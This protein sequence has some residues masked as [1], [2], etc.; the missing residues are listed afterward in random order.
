M[1]GRGTGN[2]LHSRHSEPQWEPGGGRRSRAVGRGTPP[3][4]LSLPRL[5]GLALWLLQTRTTRTDPSVTL[6]R[7]SERMRR[8]VAWRITRDTS[9]IPV[10]A[11]ARTSNSTTIQRV[12]H[13]KNNVQAI[14]ERLVDEAGKMG[15]EEEK[16]LVEWRDERGVTPLLVA[17]GSGRERA[18]QTLLSAGVDLESAD[19]DGRT[20]LVVA[21]SKG[22]SLVVEKLLEA[23]AQVD[24]AS[25]SGATA[26]YMACQQG[27]ALVVEKLVGSA[28][29][30]AATQTGATA[31]YIAAQNGHAEVVE[32]LLEAW[33]E[34][35]AAKIDGSTPIYIACSKGHHGVVEKLVAAGADVELAYHSGVAQLMVASR[36]GHVEVV[37]RL[38]K[39]GVD[40]DRS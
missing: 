40:F 3:L 25:K 16:K 9:L 37:E 7:R 35:D 19:E 14:I 30:S 10:L 12:I 18:V 6:L 20:G 15:T 36:N 34:V 39:G 21:C 22:H 23:G 31:L 11:S 29:I 28:S 26:L 38:L 13:T 1:V 2:Q 17:C 8:L 32:K 5:G 27:H 4:V 24:A 33:A